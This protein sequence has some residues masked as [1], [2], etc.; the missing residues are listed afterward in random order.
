MTGLTPTLVMLGPMVLASEMMPKM[1]NADAS[2]LA[3]TRKEAFFS[4]SPVWTD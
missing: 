4:T 3:C 1:P 2:Y